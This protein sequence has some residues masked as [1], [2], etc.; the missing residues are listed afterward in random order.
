MSHLGH[1]RPGPAG[2]RSSHVRYAP[3]ATVGHHNAIGRDG[4]IA[5]IAAAMLF[6]M[7]CDLYFMALR[8]SEPSESRHQEA[9]RPQSGCCP[10]RAAAI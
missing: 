3:K 7:K 6:G 5:D 4:P 1:S 10:S 8:K 2:R 9:Y